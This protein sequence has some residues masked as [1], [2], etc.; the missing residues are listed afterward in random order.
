M[1]NTKIPCDCCNV[2]CECDQRYHKANC[3]DF[4]VPVP[5]SLERQF[6]FSSLKVVVFFIV[7][8]FYLLFLFVLSFCFLWKVC[9]CLCVYVCVWHFILRV[10]HSSEAIC[11]TYI[12][13]L[14]CMLQVILM[15]GLCCIIE[16]FVILTVLFRL[17]KKTT[18]KKE[19]NERNKKRRKFVIEFAT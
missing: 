7:R 11:A 9:V 5:A 8:F 19:K 16:F 1:H 14:R 15:K 12:T 6:E 13:I 2:Y 18:N 3:Y 17:E 4:E 10:P